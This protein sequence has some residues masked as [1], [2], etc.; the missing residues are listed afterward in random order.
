M[1]AAAIHLRENRPPRAVGKP[2]AVAPEEAARLTGLGRTTIFGAL[3]SGA[4]ASL[5]VGRRRLIRIDVL[6][7]W[8]DSH[9]R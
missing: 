8:L 4:L 7:A 5:K 3:K 9:E 1:S 6:E 2:I